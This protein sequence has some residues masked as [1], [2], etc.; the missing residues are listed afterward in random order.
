MS[1]NVAYIA[2][3]LLKNTHCFVVVAVVVV[4]KLVLLRVYDK[5]TAKYPNVK[6]RP[7]KKRC[8][9]CPVPVHEVRGGECV[10]KAA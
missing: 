7:K 5:T 4:S 2:G 6:H 8:T 3:Q 9:S 1:K 10:K